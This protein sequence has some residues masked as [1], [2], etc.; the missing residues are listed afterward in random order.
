M[1]YIDQLLQRLAN[2]TGVG[3]QG[4]VQSV[5]KEEL[6]RIA[7]N[8]KIEKDGSVTGFHPGTGKKG[9]MIAC[10]CDEIGFLVNRIDDAGRLFFS[11]IGGSDVR[12]LP[13]QEVMV[14]GRRD[15]RGYIG[16][17][18]PHLLVADESQKVV[19]IDKL[20]IDTGLNAESVQANCRIGDCVT[21]HS[22]YRKLNNDLRTSKALDNRVGVACGLMVM[23]ELAG[24]EHELGVNFV[25]TNQEE[26][27]GL[28]ARIH[29][30]RLPVDYCIVIDVT[31]GDH[32]ELKEYE[33]FI[34]GAGPVISRGP[35]IPEKLVNILMKIAEHLDIT[36]QY[37]LSTR[38]TGTDADFIAF[39]RNGIPSC[40]V[41][42]PVRNMHSPVEVVSLKDIVRA[43]RLIT[44][45][46]RR[47][48]RTDS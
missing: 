34:L 29:S 12:I 2:A 13:G 37:E 19:P 9:I 3:Y 31:F 15:I 28:G 48:G 11:E 42:I 27:T 5:I 38:S 14:H 18:P 16:A 17:K 30:F 22:P 41:L 7:M 1:E 33:G 24:V 36:C 10:H 26:F 20:F 46:I 8:G 4:E 32:P 35:A 44:G 39:N 6:D 43:V 47:L 21:F 23:K 25:A 40:I 45:F